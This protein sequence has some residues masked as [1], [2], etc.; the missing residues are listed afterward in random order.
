MSILHLGHYCIL[1]TDDLLCSSI[2]SQME[3][4]STPKTILLRVSLICDLDE[5]RDFYLDEILELEFM[6]Q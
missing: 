1:E 2:H 4:N 5:I 6:L 3:K